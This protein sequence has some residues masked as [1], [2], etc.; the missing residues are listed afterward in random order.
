MYCKCSREVSVR[1]SEHATPWAFQG[2]L[3]SIDASGG[4]AQATLPPLTSLPLC[5]GSTTPPCSLDRP[6]HRI[7]TRRSS[8]CSND[9]QDQN[10]AQDQQRH[11]R[12]RIFLVNTSCGV[13]STTLR[14]SLPSSSLLR[15]RKMDGPPHRLIKMPIEHIKIQQQKQ[16]VL[17]TIH[18]IGRRITPRQRL[19]PRVPSRYTS[20]AQ[21]LFEH[22]TAGSPLPS[23]ET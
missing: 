23:G 17:P 20:T 4:L 7:R 8:R 6:P 2:H 11:M 10:D 21:V 22:S 3:L 9:N 13:D 1:E 5:H 15:E 14:T 16:Q 18:E 12:G 19:H